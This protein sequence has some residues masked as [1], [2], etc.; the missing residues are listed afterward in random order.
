MVRMWEE[1]IKMYQGEL[2]LERA[3]GWLS[4]QGSETAI[5]KTCW[6]FVIVM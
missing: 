3:R 6:S 1:T 2:G 4:A 5:E